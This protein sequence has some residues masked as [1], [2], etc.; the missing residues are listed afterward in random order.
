[1]EQYWKLENVEFCRIGGNK[2]LGSSLAAGVAGAAAFRRAPE[3]AELKF[4]PSCTENYDKEMAKLGAKEE[5]EE[6]A[7]STL[8]QWM[9]MAKLGSEKSMASPEVGRRLAQI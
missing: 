4:C 3:S 8:P 5:P 2:M 7:R 9:Q 6:L 1:M